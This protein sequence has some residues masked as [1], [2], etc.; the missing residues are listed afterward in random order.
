MNK[1]IS[2]IVAGLK[3]TI[4][5]KMARMDEIMDTAAEEDRTTSEE[6]STEYDALDSEVKSLR[7]DLGRQERRLALSAN[8]AKPVVQKTISDRGGVTLRQVEELEPG[9][10]FARYAMLK[11]HAKGNPQVAANLAAR[12][13]PQAD[14]LVNCL[15]AEAEGLDMGELFQQKATGMLDPAVMA[16][17]NQAI[18]TKATIAAGDTTN[19]T[20]AAPLVNAANWS[21]GFIEFLRAQTLIGQAQFAPAPFNVDIPRQIGGGTGYWT[22]E[23]KAKPLTN[24]AFD[25]ISLRFNKVAAIAVITKELA[26][27]SDPGAERIVRDQLADAVIATIDTS[28][29]DLN[30]AVPGVRPAGL[31]S[32]VTPVTTG[33][34][35]PG[36]PVSIE[37]ALLA[38]WAPWNATF[39]GRRPAYYTTPAA[40][41]VLAASRTALG[42]QAFPNMTRNGGNIGGIPVRVS[43]Y[44]ANAGGSGGAPFILVDE[45]EILLADDRTVTVDFSDQATLEMSNTPAASA[46]PT[47]VTSGTPFVNMWQT[48]CIA[49][50]AE[51]FLTWLPRRGGA[52]Q[53]IDGFPTAC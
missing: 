17:V 1:P 20:W 16:K 9:I 35:D 10:Q 31:L 53:W 43:Q 25:N 49:L 44:L 45:A 48:N 8:E 15:K 29:F 52:V 42:A 2:D 33:P 3:D 26:R 24:L 14:D 12:H 40:A 36:D 21:A 22:G 5:L 7:A 4:T 32:G 18:R 28:L 23:G 39:M 19:T 34:I 11:A 6:E 13:Y 51:R 30:A 27:F 38:L 46:N 47:V 37:C 50:R 41:M